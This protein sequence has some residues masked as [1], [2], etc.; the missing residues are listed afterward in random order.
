[1]TS[2]N[3]TSH[4]LNPIPSAPHRQPPTD[5]SSCHSRMPKSTPSPTMSTAF[6]SNSTARQIHSQPRPSPH[7][8]ICR[9]LTPFNGHNTIARHNTPRVSLLLIQLRLASAAKVVQPAAL[10]VHQQCHE[11]PRPFPIFLL[12]LFVLPTIRSVGYLL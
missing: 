3:R 5:P 4:T 7:P 8:I 11:A 12:I 10:L 6:P 1:M 9:L 2:S